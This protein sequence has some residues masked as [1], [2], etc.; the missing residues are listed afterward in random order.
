M[1]APAS[2]LALGDERF[3]SLT[4]FRKTGVPVPTTV[5]IARDGDNLIVT[6]PKDSGKVKRLRHNGRVELRPCNRRGAVADGVVSVPGIAVI[7]DDDATRERQSAVF[8]KKLGLE[9][10]IFM[11][12]ERR[13]RSGAKRRVMLKISA[14]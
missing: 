7:C 1:S 12:I 10:R 4:T 14:A 9:Y 6:T 8:L 2:F 11:F 3:V 5:W 13:G